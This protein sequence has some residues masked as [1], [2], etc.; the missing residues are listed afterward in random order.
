MKY[1]ITILVC[2]MLAMV[3]GCGEEFAAGVGT[4]M[5]AMSKMSEDA[6]TRFIETVNALDAE[7]ARLNSQIDAVQ[8][9]DIETFVNPE[10]AD[11]IKS[12]KDRKNNPVTWVALAS[13]L[14]S[15]FFGGQ[16]YANRKKR[17][18]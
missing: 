2:L 7:T 1:L 8:D 10:T 11:A 16:S 9:I 6:Q 3:A 4:G 13:V 15:A 17:P 5:A 12:L 18:E 14:G